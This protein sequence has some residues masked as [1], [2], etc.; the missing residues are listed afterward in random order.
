MNYKESDTDCVFL[1]LCKMKPLVW[2]MQKA[3]N[4]K[5]VGDATSRN[6][7]DVNRKKVDSMK[8]FFEFAPTAEDFTNNGLECEENFK[9]CKLF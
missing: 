5:I 2:S 9:T 8:V 1:L 3:V 7:D 6:G 4:S